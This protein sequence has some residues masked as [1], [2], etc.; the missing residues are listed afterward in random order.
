MEGA[1]AERERGACWGDCNEALFTTPSASLLPPLP[2]LP[3]LSRIVSRW[4]SYQLKMKMNQVKFAPVNFW[5]QRKNALVSCM[6]RNTL[7]H[8]VHM[9]LTGTDT[10]T[11]IDTLTRPCPAGFKHAPSAGGESVSEECEA[12][13]RLWESV[14]NV[15][16]HSLCSFGMYNISRV[17]NHH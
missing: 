7:L 16:N 12:R 1:S 9:S 8:F 15:H 5:P 2:P 13:A 17:I 6:Q 11:H 14:S 4:S 10:H 3:E